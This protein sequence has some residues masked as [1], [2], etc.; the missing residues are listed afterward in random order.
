M[1]APQ[2]KIAPSMRRMSL[3]SP[4]SRCAS[5]EKP[6]EWRDNVPALSYLLLGGRCRVRLAGSETWTEYRGGQ[7]FSVPGQSGL[8]RYFKP[9]PVDSKKIADIVKYEA[10]QQIPFDLNDVIWDYQQMAGGSV[11]DGF[12]RI[13]LA[14]G[15][16]PVALEVHAGVP[17]RH[18]ELV[19][20]LRLTADHSGGDDDAGRGH[21]GGACHG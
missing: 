18:E 14:A 1:S 19:T 20:A 11:E 21:R 12:A 10:K 6:V 7:S 9:P 13:D 2:L 17:P 8:A 15:E 3:S 5:C 16:F 4:P